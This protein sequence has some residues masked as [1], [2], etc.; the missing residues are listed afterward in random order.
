MDR[1]IYECN[2]QAI[3]NRAPE[4]Y[5]SIRD[6]ENSYDQNVIQVECAKNDEKI[7]CIRTDAGRLPLNSTYNPKEEARRYALQFEKMQETMVFL[8][9]GFG[10]GSFARAIAQYQVDDVGLLFYEP[11]VEVF[12]TTL[13]CF[14]ITDLI[15]DDRIAV[16]VKGLNDDR[17]AIYLDADITTGNYDMVYINSLPKYKRLYPEEYEWCKQQIV[18]KKRWLKLEINTIK[19]GTKHFMEN[20]IYNLEYVFTGKLSSQLTGAFP[21]DIPAIM[22][23]S[24]PSLDNNIEVLKQAKGHALIVAV[25]RAAPYLIDHGIEPDMVVVVDFHKSL[26]LFEKE[27]LKKIPYAIMTDVNYQVLR[28]L[29]GDSF[30]YCTTDTQLYHD[31]FHLCGQELPN[32]AIGGSVA[33]FALSLL[34]NWGFQCITMVGQDL[35]WKGTQLYAGGKELGQAYSD[36]IEVPGNTEDTV[37][38]THDFYSYLQW[39][40][41]FISHCCK[42]ITVINATEGG[43]KI[44]GTQI[45]TLQEMIDR[46]CQNDFDFSKMYQ[47]IPDIVDEEHRKEVVE[48]LDNRG[49]AI[50]KLGRLARKGESTAKRL[51]TLTERNDFGKEFRKLN[52]ELESICAEFEGDSISEFYSK[53]IA[54]DEIDI[55]MDLYFPEK[56][57]ND[58]S[59]RLYQKLVVTYSSMAEHEEEI[60][61]CY[62][63]MLSRVRKKFFGTV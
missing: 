20:P 1:S 43:A 44:A 56:D 49:K 50:S 34:W 63:E 53:S 17:V 22:V 58:E 8:I 3:R 7:L 11:S 59:I 40:E 9:L 60:Q 13:H 31:V 32:L 16:L 52:K 36:W 19:A 12:M 6:M 18:Q 25:D 33:T 10:N 47:Q 35:S 15:K 62:D 2:M 51:I 54:G 42:D 41:L 30:V 61:T 26:D 14:D 38:T 37:Y 23:S 27:G 28:K 57:T 46:Y 21:K 4:L 29:D 39:M 48:Y 5:E 55:R 45:M 24:G